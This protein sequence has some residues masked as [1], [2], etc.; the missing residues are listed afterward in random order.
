MPIPSKSFFAGAVIKPNSIGAV[1]IF[2]TNVFAVLAFID[3]ESEINRKKTLRQGENISRKERV[4]VDQTQCEV[5]LF[6]VN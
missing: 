4:K 1:C 6:F 2:V 3:V 5:I